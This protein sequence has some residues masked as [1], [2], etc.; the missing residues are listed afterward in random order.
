MGVTDEVI[1]IPKASLPQLF[2]RFYRAA[3]V[4]ASYISGLGVGLYVVKEIVTRHGGRIDV[5]S[6][7][8][9]GSTFTVWLPALGPRD[10]DA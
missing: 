7:E 2:Q 3:N 10:S 4:D 5:T 1:G 9:Q 6:I 8:G